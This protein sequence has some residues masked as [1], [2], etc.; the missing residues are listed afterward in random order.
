MIVVMRSDTRE[1]INFLY[2]LKPVENNKWKG[3]GPCHFITPGDRDMQMRTDENTCHF[4]PTEFVGG[5]GVGWNII[6]TERQAVY[7]VSKKTKYERLNQK[8]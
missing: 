7:K 3:I 5:H 2:T 4:I 8:M 1:S 6:T